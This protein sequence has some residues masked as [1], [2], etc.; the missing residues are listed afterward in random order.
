MRFF[1]FAKVKKQPTCQVKTGQIAKRK[2]KNLRKSLK[3]NAF[4][5]KLGEVEVWGYL[6]ALVVLK[7]ILIFAPAWPAGN[8]VA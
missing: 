6:D 4:I 2:L 5:N 8:P 3:V 1:A 7:Y